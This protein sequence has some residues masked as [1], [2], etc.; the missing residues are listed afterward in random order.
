MQRPGNEGSLCKQLK[1]RLYHMEHHLGPLRRYKELLAAPQATPQNQERNS[2]RAGPDG[3]PL[4]VHS[5]RKVLLGVVVAVIA[6]RRVRIGPEKIA[7]GIINCSKRCSKRI[8]TPHHP[9]MCLFCVCLF[10]FAFFF[11]SCLFSPVRSFVHPRMCW[12]R[13]PGAVRPGASA[14]RCRAGY[15]IWQDS[16]RWKTCC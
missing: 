3:T 10:V 13:S 5:M 15:D 8:I 1:T 12:L 11:F 4:L 9:R 16:W 6:D 2:D 14:Q 7:H